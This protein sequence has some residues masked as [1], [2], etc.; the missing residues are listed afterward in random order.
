MISQLI[1]SFAIYKLTQH[2]QSH[3]RLIHRHHVACI[4]NS[5]ESQWSKRL[6][7]TS[8]LSASSSPS[9]DSS[10]VITFIS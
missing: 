10:L 5:Q 1:N 2:L 7:L 3:L 9:L 6:A 4:K 8:L